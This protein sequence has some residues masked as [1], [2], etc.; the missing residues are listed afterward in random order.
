MREFVLD[1][2]LLGDTLMEQ[3]R[4]SD[5]AAAYQKMIDLKPFY[6]SYTRAAHLRWLK[7]DLGGAVQMMHAAVQAASPR[8][9]E[10]VAW[11]YSRLAAVRVAARAPR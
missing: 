6:Q 11:A 4:V 2:G 1:F 8:D 5:A 9:R 3:G 7:G 10:S